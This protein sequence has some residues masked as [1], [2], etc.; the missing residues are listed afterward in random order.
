MGQLGGR[1][2]NN[3]PFSWR[4]SRGLGGSPFTTQSRGLGAVKKNMFVG[5]VQARG[6]F[7]GAMY[8]WKGLIVCLE[9]KHL[10]GANIVAPERS[11]HWV[12][13]HEERCR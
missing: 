9:L 8:E 1:M 13:G 3:S 12:S 5:C 2:A 7:H 10:I 4:D 6:K 11:G